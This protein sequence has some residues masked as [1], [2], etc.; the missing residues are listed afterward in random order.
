MPDEVSAIDQP[1]SLRIRALWPWMLLVLTLVSLPYLVAWLAA[2]PETNF[3]GSLVN[4]DDLSVYLAAMRQGE[5]GNWLY[6]STFSA[7]AWQPHLM[8][9]PYLLLGRLLHLFE[10]SILVI[11]LSRLLFVIIAL[12]AVLYVVRQVFS[13]QPRLQKTA[14]LLI[15]F[16]SGLGWLSVLFF[17]G[18]LPPDLG[19]PEWSTLMALFHTPH[20]A[21]GLALE[22]LLFGTV[23]RLG[24]HANA[25]G[26]LVVAVLLAIASALTY[27]YHIPV[28]GLTIGLYLLAEAVSRRRIPRWH[29]ISGGLV[30]LVLALLLLYYGLFIGQDDPYFAHYTAVDHVIPPPS[31]SGALIGLGLPG[32]LAVVALRP[33]LRAGRSLLVPIW[34]AANLL[35]L[36]L[37]VVQFSGRFALGLL[38]PV[39]MLATFG[40]EEVLLPGLQA[41]GFLHRVFQRRRP[42]PE[43]LRR[44]VLLLTVPSTIMIPL[45]AMQGALLAGGFPYYV[46]RSEVRAMEWLAANSQ[47]DDVYFAHYPAGNYLPR[48]AP[49]RVFLGQLDF[50]HELDEKL[51][52]LERFWDEQTSDAWR[53]ALMASWEVTYI[54]EGVHE[55]TITRGTV[56][57]P[58]EIAY[59]EDNVTIYRLLWE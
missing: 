19:G 21:L 30:L 57:P 32:L 38:V 47:A 49:G 56:T 34:A 36:Y 4:H 43:S 24:R 35:A 6:R 13:G 51:A 15:V 50:T 33:W 58:G 8:L 55:Q 9:L 31:L 28:A 26:W 52:V 48:L 1:A 2:P 16:G 12:L 22:L 10:S 29:W 37:P 23:I 46:P 40:L 25:W 41:E 53:T 7:E 59:Q 18:A 27:V 11:H 39:A 5:A 14:W 42:S 17:P 44:M 54:Y 45:F 20:F 3:A